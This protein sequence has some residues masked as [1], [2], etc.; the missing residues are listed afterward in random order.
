MH[1]PAIGRLMAELVLDGHAG[2]M[3]I[4][5]LSLARFAR[6]TARPEANMF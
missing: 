3:D 6:G 4:A 2:S 5:P 1:A